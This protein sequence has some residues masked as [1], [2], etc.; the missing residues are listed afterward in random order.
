MSNIDKINELFKD[1]S[2]VKELLSK[3]EPEEAQLFLEEHG[4]MMSLDEIMQVGEGLKKIA[5]G[6]VSSETV[7]KIANGELGE[8]ELENVAGGLVPLVIPII[9]GVA[10]GAIFGTVAG[11]LDLFEVNW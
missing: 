8:D 2:I 11:L 10:S 7:S 1:E 4:V 5:K 3:K 9:A 6:E